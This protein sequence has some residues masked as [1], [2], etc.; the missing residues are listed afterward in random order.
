MKSISPIYILLSFLIVASACSY[1]KKETQA[2]KNG[3]YYYELEVHPSE[4][5][6]EF[7]ISLS[8]LSDSTHQVNLP[9][10]YYGTPQIDKWVTSFKGTNGTQVKEDESNSKLVT[11]N[12]NNEVHLNYTI[13]YDPGE[14]DKYSYAPKV[15][16][17]YF[18][19]AG[20]QWILPTDPIDSVYII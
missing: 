7:N 10:D 5:D 9:K 20:C 15:A 11:P 6:L 12:K 13:K 18:Y 4:T 2:L 1:S 14:I 3:F 17:G 8:Y 16:P 19:M